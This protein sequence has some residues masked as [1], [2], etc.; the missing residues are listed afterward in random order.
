MTKIRTVEHGSLNASQKI[1]LLT[2]FLVSSGMSVEEVKR[3][4]VLSTTDFKVVTPDGRHLMI[5]AIVKNISGSGWSWK[6]FV[7]RIQIKSYSKVS[8]P[9]NTVD[10]ITL[11]GGF[12]VV[13]GEYVYAAWNIFAYMSQKTV[14]SCY[15]G[16]ENLISALDHGFVAT[17][18][19]D[20]HVYLSD[21]RNMLRLIDGF[22]QQNAVTII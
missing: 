16:T 1:N 18:Y 5:H 11:L 4:N 22:I 17:V 7:K 8:L 10:E 9:V 3:N 19:A 12:A 14:R 15:V 2:T 13:D 21:R 20:N 6:P